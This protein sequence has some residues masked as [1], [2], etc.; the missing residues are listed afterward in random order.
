LPLRHKD[1]KKRSQGSGV[2]IQK[3]IIAAKRLKR[4]E[5]KRAENVGN[6]ENFVVL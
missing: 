1:T 5:R 3:K 2:R 6:Y 4:H